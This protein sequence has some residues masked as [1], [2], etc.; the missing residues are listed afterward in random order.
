MYNLITTTC[1]YLIYL[2]LSRNKQPLNVTHHPP[3]PSLSLSPFSQAH[4]QSCSLPAPSH[5]L[6]VGCSTGISSRYLA[7]AWP[8]AHVTGIDLSPY[9]L[10]V[11]EWQNRRCGGHQKSCRTEPSWSEPWQGRA[12][13]MC[14]HPFHLRYNNELLL[15]ILFAA[16]TPGLR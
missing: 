3:H 14:C 10:A 15:A 4:F 7:A 5:I 6:D 13:H 9:F 1:I 11:A 16:G 2:Y 12:E 8:Q